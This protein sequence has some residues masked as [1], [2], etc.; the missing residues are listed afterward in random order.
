MPTGRLFLVHFRIDGC[1]E[2]VAKDTDQ[3]WELARTLSSSDL[4]GRRPGGDRDTR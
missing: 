3:A 1:V 4:A 2:I